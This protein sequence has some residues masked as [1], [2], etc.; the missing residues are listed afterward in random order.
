MMDILFIIY[1]WLK[2]F[3]VAMVVLFAKHRLACDLVV[4]SLNV[5]YFT[6]SEQKV[7][8]RA[9]NLEFNSE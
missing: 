2:Y 3:L 4:I 9:C 5:A 7:S 8:V 1:P 6:F